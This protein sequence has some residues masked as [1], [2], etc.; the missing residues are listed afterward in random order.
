[1]P[2]VFRFPVRSKGCIRERPAESGPEL[3]SREPRTGSPSLE[4]ENLHGMLGFL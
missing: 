4:A 2:S 3:S 1:M